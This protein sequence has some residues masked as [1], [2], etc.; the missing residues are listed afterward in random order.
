[1]TVRELIEI[2]SSMDPDRIIV[3][4]DDDEGNGYRP[5]H[6]ISDNCAY[7]DHEIGMESLSEKDRRAGY[8]EEDIMSDGHPCVVLW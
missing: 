5:A 2:L 6:C 1:M 8:T 4:S 3:L 7:K